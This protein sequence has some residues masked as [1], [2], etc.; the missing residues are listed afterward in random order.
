MAGDPVG[1]MFARRYDGCWHIEKEKLGDTYVVNI[2]MD[3]MYNISD[4]DKVL[5]E[6]VL[7]R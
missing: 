2:I 3:A 4:V 5:W 6:T 7:K 1:P